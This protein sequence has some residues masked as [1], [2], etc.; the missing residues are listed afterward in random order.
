M[1]QRQSVSPATKVGDKWVANP[2]APVVHTSKLRNPNDGRQ[3]LLHVSRNS[4]L[5][6]LYQ[7]ESAWKATSTVL[8]PVESSDQVI[9]HAAINEHGDHAIVVTH[10]LS[11]RF[12]IYQV[13]INWNAPQSRQPNQIVPV[14]PNLE[15]THLSVV[16]NIHSQHSSAA[17]LTL[18]R[19][20]PAVADSGHGT[21]SPT[22]ILAGFTHAIP[23]SGLQ[24]PPAFSVLAHWHVDNAQP[25]LHESFK[26]MKTGPDTSSSLDQV[27]VLRRQ[28]DIITNKVIVSLDVP[29]TSE[30]VVALLASDGTLDFRDRFTMNNSLEPY[31]DS[32]QVTSLAQSGFEHVLE[33]HHLHVATSIDGCCLVVAEADDTML[34]KSMVFRYGWH[35]TNDGLVD[36]QAL[37]EAG[38]ICIARQYVL[39]CYANAS[40][41][42]SLALIPTQATQET[43]A[44]I[45]AMIVRTLTPYVDLALLD[46][47]KQRGITMDSGM[48][49]CMSA[50]LA[51]GT[52]YK[53]GRRSFPGQFAHI[54]LSIR[55]LNASSFITQELINRM[56]R[57]AGTK[58]VIPPDVAVSFKGHIKWTLNLAVAIV[59]TLMR[60]KQEAADNSETTA[61]QTI[62][63]LTADTSTP[64]AHIL[65]SSPT[66]F[67]LRILA[68]MV[69]RYLEMANQNLP[70][71]QSE[72]DKTQLN[73]LI[74]EMSQF[75]FKLNLFEALMT[76]FDSAIR[77][78]YTKSGATTERRAE[79]EWALMCTGTIPPEFRP[80]IDMLL[81]TSLPK[82]LEGADLGKLHLWDTSS[83]AQSQ[84]GLAAD[85]KRYDVVRKTPLLDT[86]K[87][88][89]CRRC[90]SETEDIPL[91]D[92]HETPAWLR[93][94][95]RYCICKSHWR[96]AV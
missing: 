26:K 62:A 71:T 83:I 96:L 78:V 27:T 79:I 33:Q 22:T 94:E 81:Q 29:L 40:G 95:G 88:R 87:L 73:N 57:P 86:M 77:S 51:I 8:E 44:L 91:K 18:L 84:I 90:G 3:A 60:V 20:L 45:N 74:S 42:E 43:R 72:Y 49:R 63:K 53:T 93:A 11:S 12:R 66:R 68:Q 30:A 89:V 6:L 76:E 58:P 64:F 7:S 67:M 25:A 50:Q 15:V 13:G 37:I 2:Q 80:A 14:S 54:T 69:S 92:A 5:T 28:P 16:D 48:F 38:A 36:N 85:G 65:I 70:R 52:D 23:S 1:P 21:S 59:T 75:P 41:D 32:T 10:D 39:S 19:V 56:P 82:L 34:I 31:G 4:K 24:T 61:L 55:S 46:A 47:T 9:T 35:A 17:I